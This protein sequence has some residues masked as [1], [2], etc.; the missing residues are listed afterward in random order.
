MA[1]IKP[2]PLILNIGYG[3][4]LSIRNFVLVKAQPKNSSFQTA[5]TVELVFTTTRCLIKYLNMCSLISCV[6]KNF[7]IVNT[8]YTFIY[9]SALYILI[10]KIGEYENKI[11][12][13]RPK[14]N[15]KYQNCEWTNEFMN[16]KCI[17]WKMNEN[18]KRTSQVSLT[19][20]FS[21]DE[22]NQI[23]MCCVS[24]RKPAYLNEVTDE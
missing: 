4:F 15:Y 24:D 9:S 21:K 5:I 8:K 17:N 6:D 18:K 20:W 12:S 19:R 2:N 23:K 11:L 14:R 10:F 7:Q 13:K 16:D 3:D 22:R 1:I